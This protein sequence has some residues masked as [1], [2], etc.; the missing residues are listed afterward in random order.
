ML[1]FQESVKLGFRYFETDLHLSKDGVLMA[2]HDDTLDRTTDGTGPLRDF[3]A[4]ELKEFDAAFRFGADRAWPYRGHGL[5]IPTL[6]ELVSALPDA[7]FT[8]ELK[9]AGLARPLVEFLDYL[10]LWQRVIIGGYS[11]EW[12]KEVRRLSNGRVLTSTAKNETLRFW[13]ASR[14]GLALPTAAV[15]LQV[16]VQHRGLTVVDRRFVRAAHR[17][18]KQVHVWT[19]NEPDEMHRLLDL[20]VDGLMSDVPDVLLAVMEE[21]GVGGPHQPPG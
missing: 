8:F 13:L 2:F 6:E 12:V 1:A 14:V 20:G 5:T 15:A 18:G 3:T 9:E 19:I 21:R 10:N 11:D 17:A 16:P 4:T 7:F